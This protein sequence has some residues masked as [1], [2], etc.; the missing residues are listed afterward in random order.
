METQRHDTNESQRKK[1]LRFV[2]PIY[3]TWFTRAHPIS[4]FT[5]ICVYLTTTTFLR[6]SVSERALVTTLLT[7]ITM[8][9]DNTGAITR[10][11]IT[12][13]TVLTRT[14]FVTFESISGA[15]T[16]HFTTVREENGRQ[17]FMMRQ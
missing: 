3:N 9:T 11:W 4:V 12:I 6:A 8:E 10:H 16:W 1:A 17:I 14:L 7:P 5:R 2:H 15:I 13:S